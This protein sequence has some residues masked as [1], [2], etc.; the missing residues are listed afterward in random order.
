MR[1]A[2]TQ[3][4]AKPLALKFSMLQPNSIIF[5]IAGFTLDR[6]GISADVRRRNYEAPF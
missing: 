3:V 2:D 5:R 6:A 1:S 4:L